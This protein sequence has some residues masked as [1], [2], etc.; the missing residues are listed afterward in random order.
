MSG[1]EK[2]FEILSSMVNDDRGLTITMEIEFEFRQDDGRDD[3]R[4]R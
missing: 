4:L 1:K 2:H 3:G